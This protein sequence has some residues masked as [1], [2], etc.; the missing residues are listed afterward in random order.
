MHISA[1]QLSFRRKLANL[2][3]EYDASIHVV[4]ADPEYENEEISISIKLYHN[5]SMAVDSY[6]KEITT[7]RIRDR[8]KIIR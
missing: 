4:E 5:H 3:E 1:K 7:K 2:L 6:E 8:I